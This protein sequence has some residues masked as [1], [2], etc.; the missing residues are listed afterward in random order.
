[1][2]IFAPLSDAFSNTTEN[3][4]S[5]INWNG[6]E[7]FDF[8]LC[9]IRSR[10]C[11]KHW[12]LHSPETFRPNWMSTVKTDFVNKEFCLFQLFGYEFNEV[13]DIDCGNQLHRMLPFLL[14]IIGSQVDLRDA[15]L[16]KKLAIGGLRV[17]NAIL[18][19]LNV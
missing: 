3:K 14:P 10:F 12:T 2:E 17:Q 16:K 5:G 15:T 6:W 4:V 9:Q 7:L 11:N 18:V 19:V 1:M 8:L 13:T